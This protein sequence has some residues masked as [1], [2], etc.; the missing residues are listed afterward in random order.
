MFDIFGLSAARPGPSMAAPHWPF[1]SVSTKAFEL[2]AASRKLPPAAQ[3]PPGA[4]DTEVNVAM[5]PASVLTAAL[6]IP[7]AVPVAD[8]ATDA[9]TGTA[10]AST[11]LN[12]LRTWHSPARQRC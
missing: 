11:A 10:I 2:V 5:L 3:V 1:S 9:T 6:A 8:N 7:A 4:Q 12:P